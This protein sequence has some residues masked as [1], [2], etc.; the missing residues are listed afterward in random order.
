MARRSRPGVRIL[1]LHIGLEGISP[2]VWRRV[3]VHDR[4]TMAGLHQTIQS[5]MGWRNHHL[6]VFSIRGQEYG[7]PDADWEHET[8]D[9]TRTLVADLGFVEGDTF[10]YRYH[11]GDAWEHRLSVEIVFRPE[12][13]VHYPLVVAGARNCPPERAG[14]PRGYMDLLQALA[15]RGDSAPGED[16]QWVARYDPARYDN[17]TAQQR[18]GRSL[19]RLAFDMTM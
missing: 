2:E 18:V 6:H 1:Q 14:G 13:G 7:A 9:E 12:P 3:Q 15:T 16:R 4:I 5:A 8:G 10:S 17:A 19:R 11:V